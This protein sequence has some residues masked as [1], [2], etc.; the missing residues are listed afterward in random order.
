MGSSESKYVADPNGPPPNN[1]RHS[2]QPPQN[3]WITFQQPGHHHQQRPHSYQPPP[4]PPP[5]APHLPPRPGRHG[6]YGRPAEQ[7]PPLPPRFPIFNTGWGKFAVGPSPHRPD[8]LAHGRSSGRGLTVTDPDGR[9]V[10]Q[11]ETEGFSG[12][13]QTIS[14]DGGPVYR[15]S[16]KDMKKWE[17]EVQGD[18]FRWKKASESE[19]KPLGVKKVRRGFQMLA[20]NGQLVA[21]L[22]REKDKKVW[23]FAF[24]GLAAEGARDGDWMLA[25][26]TSG[27][28][29]LHV[30]IVKGVADANL[31]SHLTLSNAS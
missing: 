17:V 10:V 1:Y 19:L 2:H 22:G 25:V 12:R 24:F 27:I 21:L 9:T 8:Y 31:S 18:T 6:G 30:S 26:A 29:V 3:D 15:M 16:S 28:M 11:C 13:K 5:G 20:P 4:G 23:H 7:L 14:I